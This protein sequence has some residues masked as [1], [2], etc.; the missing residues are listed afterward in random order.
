MDASLFRR[1]VVGGAGSKGSGP[2]C[3]D[4]IE[5]P[6]V[7]DTIFAGNWRV[8]DEAYRGRRGYRK[9]RISTAG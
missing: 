7:E 1:G 2:A 3:A 6:E 8:R 9:A 4:G 5:V